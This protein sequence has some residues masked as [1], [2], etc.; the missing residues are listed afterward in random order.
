MSQLAIPRC[1][2]EWLVHIEG[3][4]SRS[5]DLGLR[6]VERV[7]TALGIAQRAPLV[8]VGGTGRLKWRPSREKGLKG[9]LVFRHDGRWNKDPI[10]RLTPEPI[11][12]TE[13]ALGYQDYTEAR[14]R[15][16]IFQPIPVVPSP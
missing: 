11:A 2:D 4:H 5:I 3:V 10:S 15:A 6:R 1:L 14:F 9:Y 7:K 8:T 12:A 16:G 13:F